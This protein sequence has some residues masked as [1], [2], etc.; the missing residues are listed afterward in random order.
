MSATNPDALD[1]QH[2]YPIKTK[3]TPLAVIFNIISGGLI[4]MAELVPGISGGTVA[5][6]LGIYERALHNGDLSLI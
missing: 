6:V 5:L 4:G 1:V 2:V 3:K